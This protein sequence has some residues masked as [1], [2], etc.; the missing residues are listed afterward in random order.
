MPEL[1]SILQAGREGKNKER[2]FLAALQGINLDEG[3][4][5]G[6]PSFE[7][8]KRRALGLDGD[9]T[10]I[11]GQSAV[12]NGFGIGQGLGYREE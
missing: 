8:V 11:Q 5:D 2:E 1:L 3:G 4:K 9:V 12:D 10:K 7:D 6:L